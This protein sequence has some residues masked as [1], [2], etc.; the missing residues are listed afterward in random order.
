MTENVKSEV[1]AIERRRARR[2]TVD[3]NV[4]VRQ[5]DE[6]GSNVDE[7]GTLRNLSSRGASL[8]LKEILRVGTKMELWIRMPSERERWIAY[9][10]EIV[11]IDVGRYEVGTATK[12]LTVRPRLHLTPREI[13]A[14]KLEIVR[15][16]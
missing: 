13:P 9:P 6:R 12:F 10:A 14:A 15:R 16:R 3:W 8:S 4:V 1:A 2:F 7:P 5:K 11:R